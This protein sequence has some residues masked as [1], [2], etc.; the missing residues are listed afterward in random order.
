MVWDSPGV[1]WAS[2]PLS[3]DTS[4]SSRL[5]DSRGDRAAEEDRASGGSGGAR[6]SPSQRRPF[7]RWSVPGRTLEPRGR[8][9]PPAPPPHAASRAR[10]F[11]GARAL[12]GLWCVPPRPVSSPPGRGQPPWWVRVVR[13]G[14]RPACPHRPGT[15]SVGLTETGPA[16][17]GA[18]SRSGAHGAGLTAVPQSP[19]QG[20]RFPFGFAGHYSYSENR[21]ERDGLILTSRGPGTSFEFALAIVEA[22]NGKDVADQVKAPLVLKD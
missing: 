19:L 17:L 2:G 14:A 5:M 21:V 20:N 10:A 22:L 1:V 18:G 13:T 4:P 16:L 8:A 15:G 11:A 12:R 9:W 7:C 3:C 6:G